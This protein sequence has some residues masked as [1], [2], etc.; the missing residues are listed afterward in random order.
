MWCKAGAQISGV[1]ED[2]INYLNNPSLMH[3]QSVIV[4]AYPSGGSVGDFG[5]SPDN[6][7]WKIL[8]STALLGARLQFAS[9]IPTATLLCQ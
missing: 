7:E 8:C 5:Q 9:K 3:A 6:L 4:S 2:G 1:N